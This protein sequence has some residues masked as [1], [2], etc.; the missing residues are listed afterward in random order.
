MTTGGVTFKNEAWHRDCFTCA[1]CREPLA[2]QKFAARNDQPYCAKCFGQLF[3]K[4]C[5][6]CKTPITGTGGTKFITYDG[7]HWH[8]ACFKCAV[9]K[10]SMAGKGFINDGD[11]ISCPDCA[12]KKFMGMQGGGGSGGSTPAP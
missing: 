9:C 2:G 1:H 11:D 12:T 6:A 10:E 7:Q 5:T 4:R 3:A 8:S